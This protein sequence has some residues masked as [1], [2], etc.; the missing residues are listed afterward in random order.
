MYH[1]LNGALEEVLAS[2]LQILLARQLNKL[3]TMSLEGSTWQAVLQHTLSQKTDYSV[4]TPC[5]FLPSQY[6]D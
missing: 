5:L 1:I 4:G 6:D 2:P 3:N